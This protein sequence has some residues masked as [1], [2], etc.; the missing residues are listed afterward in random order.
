MRLLG[1]ISSLQYEPRQE[2][3]LQVNSPRFLFSRALFAYL[4]LQKNTVS[5][6]FSGINCHTNKTQDDRQAQK[7]ERDQFAKLLLDLRPPSPK[8]AE[9]LLQLRY[10]QQEL[11]NGYLIKQI[12]D[13]YIQGSLPPMFTQLQSLSSTKEGRDAMRSAGFGPLLGMTRKSLLTHFIIKK[14]NFFESFK[15]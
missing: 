6:N 13:S 8:L 5:Y 2:F 10:F 7:R 1:S 14:N 4:L 3:L 9:V 12:P 11:F 15:S